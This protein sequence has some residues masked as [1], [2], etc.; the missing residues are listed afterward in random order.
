M[1]VHFGPTKQIKDSLGLPLPKSDNKG[2][3]FPVAEAYP[4]PCKTSKMKLFAKIVDGFQP[5]TVFAKSAILIV[6]LIS[7]YASKSS[8]FCSYLVYFP[9]QA[10]KIKKNHLETNSSYFRK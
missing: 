8:I 2:V 7:K 5:S 10:R 4:R 9:A 1:N 6:C 3:G